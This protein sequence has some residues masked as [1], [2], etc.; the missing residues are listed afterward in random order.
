MSHTESHSP[1]RYKVSDLAPP[2]TCINAVLRILSSGDAMTNGGLAKASGFA[3]SM[4]Q[5]TVLRLYRAGKLARGK[6][7]EN[8]KQFAYYIPQPAKGAGH[9]VVARRG[10]SAG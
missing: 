7:G 9:A 5:E 6:V 8:M 10:R 1:L 2:E 4:V 3:E